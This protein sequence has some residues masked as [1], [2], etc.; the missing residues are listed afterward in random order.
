ICWRGSLDGSAARVLPVCER[1]VALL[2]ERPET[3]DSRGLARALTGN[4]TGAIAG[5]TAYIAS[6][7]RY[8]QPAE[9]TGDRPGR[10]AGLRERRTAFDATTVAALRG[11]E[12]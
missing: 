11:R 8:W 12:G 10:V 9:R 1:A 4:A 7:G 2:P 5:F 6:R 3:R